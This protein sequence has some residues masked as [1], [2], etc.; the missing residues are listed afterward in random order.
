MSIIT[1]EILA[2]HTSMILD[3]YNDG[4]L[5]ESMFDDGEIH[6][7]VFNTD[8]FIVGYYN[9]SQWLKDHNIDAFGLI[10]FVQEYENTNFGETH[11]KINSESMLNM[12]SYIIGEQALYD[13][14]CSDWEE[15]EEKMQELNQE[16]N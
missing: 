12:F 1:N 6:Q 9:A 10:D 7:E 3:A 15:F 16:N 11:T 13:L 8:Y 5:N 14:N 2:I 4:R